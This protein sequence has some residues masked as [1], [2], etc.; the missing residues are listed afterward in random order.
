MTTPSP[1]E[2]DRIT[3]VL[4]PPYIPGMTEMPDQ[5]PYDGGIPLRAVE[6]DLQVIINAWETMNI[7]DRVE[8]F[9]G[10]SSAPVWSKT[11]ELESE[12]NKDV[13]FRIAEGF[14][15]D[16][17]ANP[18]FYRITRPT[19]G[20]QD[21]TPI[22]TLLVK[23]TRPGG[24]DDSP[25]PG[26]DGLKYTLTPD[27]SNGVDPGMAE[28]GVQMRIEPYENITVYDRI[29]ARW[30]SQEVV[31]SRVTQEE[32]DDPTNHP[33]L[34]TFTKAVIEAAGDGPRVAVT[35][36]VID[37]CNNYPDERAP[38]AAYTYVLVDLG[39]NRLNAPLVLVE[40][41]PTNTIDLELLGEA[42][43][44]VRVYTPETDF[45]V[46][47][48]VR[49]TWSGTPAE[50][51]PIVVGPLEQT[52]EFV[53]FHRDFLIPNASVK[54]IAK[55]WATVSYQRVRDGVANRPSKNASVDVVGEIS[56]LLPPSVD[57]APGGTLPP[58]TLWATVSIPWYPG[59]KSSDQVTLIWEAK[60]GASTVYYEDPRPVG[61]I[62]DHHPVLRSVSNAEIRRFDGLKVK[63]YYRVANDE[64]LVHSVRESQS[65]WMQVGEV[66]PQFARPEVEEV[67]P[68]SDVLD[69]DNVPPTGATLLV[70]F[71]GTQAGDRVSFRWRGSASGGSTSDF[72][73]LTSQ[74]AG[75][76]VKF[77]VGKQFVTPNL[78]GTVF[79]DYSI[80]RN[81]V[82]L[83]QS[84]EL[85]LRVG[86]AQLDLDPPSVQEA[87]PDGKT[88]QPLKAE[89]SLTV[90]I[91]Q[92]DLS[93]T[94]LLSVKWLSAPGTPDEGSH[95]TEPRPISEI[96]LSI[97]L[98]MKLIPFSLG[99]AVTLTYIIIRGN[100]PPQTSKPLTL[101]VLP[102]VLGDAYRPKLKQA[103][104]N[105]EGPELHLK[106]LT[107]A[108]LMWFSDWP[109]IALGQYVWLTLSGTKA[110]GDSYH[111]V[112]WASPS[113]HTNQ[114]WIDQGFFEASAPF[115][116]LME[117]KDGS[118]LT[119]AFKAGLGGSQNEDEAVSFSERT[120]AIKAARVLTP[121][122]TNPP[123]LIKQAGQVKDI[124]LRLIDDHSQPVAHGKLKL[125]L[126]DGFTYSDGGSGEREFTSES[127]GT[128]TVSGVKGRSTLGGY[129]LVAVSGEQSA[130]ERVVI[131]GIVKSI[132]VGP[133][134]M[135][136]ALNPD[137]SRAFAGQNA[138]SKIAVIDTINQKVIKVIQTYQPYAMTV[139]RDGT[140]L[141]VSTTNKI[142][143]Y[144]AVSHQLTGTIVITGKSVDDIA[145]APD[146]KRAFCAIGEG[147]PL[148]PSVLIVDIV[149]PSVI[150]AVPLGTGPAYAVRN[151]ALTPDGKQ[152][153]IG[154]V[155]EGL[156]VFDIL[157]ERVVGT[158]PVKLASG[159]SIAISP[160][161]TRAICVS[162]IG[163]LVV[164]DTG[165]WTVIG[166]IPIG[167]AGY[168]YLAISPDGIRVVVPSSNAIVIVNLATLAIEITIPV[169]GFAWD[170]AISPD[171]TR[172]FMILG[173][174]VAIVA[175][176]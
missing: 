128:V 90:L 138:E 110:N 3:A 32:I 160:D 56:H 13:V 12:L 67:E 85:R 7:G 18:V 1:V 112:I 111:Q 137:G 150:K 61:N 11:I 106:D 122:F 47:D 75:K 155:T 53:P 66:A 57:E 42:D 154:P 101:S 46:G 95:T 25:E 20:P 89:T 82:T 126:P 29:I 83:G 172:A 4:R 94:D 19:Q 121:T 129:S 16:G 175:V 81:G 58:E 100:A 77:T 87:E 162:E 107:A 73:D 142:S 151:I 141:I 65:F 80:V 74:T 30:G 23:R 72:V 168:G 139:T 161:G 84:F 132:F 26:H 143:F 9:W 31:H 133:E 17:D 136:I 130:T 158:V 96:G 24:L 108:G 91:P 171:G 167:G 36:Q 113:A 8:M 78:N 21:S 164:I 109:F 146:G 50:G 35:Y 149:N 148:R 28:Q 39:G 116:E 2:L 118:A 45:A 10:N 144:D 63:V 159:R 163:E 79:A 6:G 115:A 52:V 69:P 125:I 68:G 153:L 62:A 27:I 15:L 156:A 40:G 104:N 38:W 64:A 22:L 105:G 120:Y 86:S 134:L 174:S 119:M 43:V 71:L 93:A 92:G 145:V 102:L 103:A 37:R 48:K 114:E 169:D 49:M 88:L 152:A 54:A 34:I 60:R 135:R 127:D 147:N 51:G 140:R 176:G 173:G 99:K 33:I 14:I 97:A 166:T 59:R 98:P 165:S 131:T 44:I 170:I 41:R 117:L 124:V 55:G 157:N 76:V 5:P 70:P 123:Y